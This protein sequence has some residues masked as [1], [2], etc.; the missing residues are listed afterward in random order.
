MI[1]LNLIRVFL[2]SV[3]MGL[4]GPALAVDKTADKKTACTKQYDACY[5]KCR[6]KHPEQDLSGDAAR[7][8]CGSACAASRTKCLAE[9]EFEDKAKPALE[10]LIDDIKKTLDEWLKKMPGSKPKENNEPLKT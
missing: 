5:A 6:T 3:L 2:V 7:T 10:K 4:T 8:A 9:I 1:K